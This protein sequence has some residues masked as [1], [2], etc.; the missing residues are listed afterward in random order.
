MRSRFRKVAIAMPGLTKAPTEICRSV[1]VPAKGA[2]SVSMSSCTE[3]N[4]KSDSAAARAA[5]SRSRSTVGW[6]PRL[7]RSRTRARF[8]RCRSRWAAA[9][10]SAAWALRSSSCTSGAPASTAALSSNSRR[11]TMP[12][13]WEAIC[14]SCTATISPTV[15]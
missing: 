2:R 13:V 9:L 15:R 11:S 10:L 4:L 6:S 8:W 5:V 1:R 14:T 7:A 12:A 3:R